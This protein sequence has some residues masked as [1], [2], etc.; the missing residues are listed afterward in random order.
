[1]GQVY[2]ASDF[3]LGHRN[4]HKFRCTEKGFF[5]DFTDEATHREWLKQYWCS[6]VTKRCKVFL[7][8]D[9]C[10]TQEALDDFKTWPGTKVLIAGNHDLDNVS[11]KEIVESG[12]YS[13]IHSLLRYKEFWLSHAPIHE[14]E[15]RGKK[16]CHGHTHYYKVDDWRYYNCCVEYGIL[17]RLEDIRSEFEKR[18]QQKEYCYEL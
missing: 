5:R 10:F 15:L 2:I 17:H 6:V 4:I 9:I 18:K 8:G 14:S 3:H 1:M 7:L 13:E 11:M 12:V 16:N